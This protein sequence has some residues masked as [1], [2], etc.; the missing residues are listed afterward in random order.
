[1]IYRAVTS[2]PAAI[3]YVLHTPLK[4]L[5]IFPRAIEWLRDF[6]TATRRSDVT[7]RFL[8]QLYFCEIHFLP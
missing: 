4:S 2:V 3:K 1:V 8:R 5:L 7:H 6:S